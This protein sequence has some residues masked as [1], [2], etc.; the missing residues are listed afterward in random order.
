MPGH[1]SLSSPGAVCPHLQRGWE[2]APCLFG[3]LPHRN[4]RSKKA[5]RALVS[6]SVHL[7][8]TKMPQIRRSCQECHLQNLPPSAPA[9][10]S[11]CRNHKFS[12][13]RLPS[14]P[15]HLTNHSYDSSQPPA[16]FFFFLLHLPYSSAEAALL[17]T[18]SI[19][20]PV[21]NTKTKHQLQEGVTGRTTSPHLLL[22]QPTR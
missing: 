1:G 19:P 22:H 12:A 4:P 9:E 5:D 18:C 6:Q 15:H 2:S 16:F 21:G 13:L 14:K 11:C 7:S 10:P 17:T 8:A 20:Q 3:S